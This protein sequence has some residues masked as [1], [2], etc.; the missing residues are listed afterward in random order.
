MCLIVFV[1]LVNILGDY[2]NLILLH[3]GELV[4]HDKFVF[5]AV[6]VAQK[7]GSAF[8]ARVY[9]R[10]SED[11]AEQTVNQIEVVVDHGAAC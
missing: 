9:L 2:Q 6:D 1:L 11:G 3:L 7:Q 10:D 4:F 5:T 8:V